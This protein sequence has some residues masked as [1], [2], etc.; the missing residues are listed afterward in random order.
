MIFSKDMKFYLYMMMFS[1][2]VE[3]IECGSTNY[4]CR[5]S[6]SGHCL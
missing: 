6:I 5:R 2:S 4:R 1:K 3:T